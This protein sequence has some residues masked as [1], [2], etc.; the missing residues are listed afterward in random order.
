MNVFLR[1]FYH[2]ALSVICAGDVVCSW[3]T[4]PTSIPGPEGPQVLSAL[5][6]LCCVVLSGQGKG[7][8]CST[9]T[10]VQGT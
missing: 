10:I 8:C 4:Q 9:N 6:E 3:S 5:L 2:G 1:L 7:S